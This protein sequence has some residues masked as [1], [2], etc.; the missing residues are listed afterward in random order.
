MHESEKKAGVPRTKAA[1][2][3]FPK[4]SKQAK[5]IGAAR[6]LLTTRPAAS[7]GSGPAG[8]A[9]PGRA[10]AAAG[11][12]SAP[13]AAQAPVVETEYMSD[14]EYVMVVCHAVRQ[15]LEP[16]S[17]AGKQ[18]GCLRAP[19]RLDCSRPRRLLRNLLKCRSWVCSGSRPDDARTRC[20]GV[21]QGVVASV[22][23]SQM[24]FQRK[25]STT[26]SNKAL[27]GPRC[28]LRGSMR[29]TDPH[30]LGA[31]C[32]QCRWR[33]VAHAVDHTS[34]PALAS[35]HQTVRKRRPGCGQRLC[36]WVAVTTWRAT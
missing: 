18:F 32:A 33:L 9:P 19:G 7:A 25:C 6:S 27:K 24:W 35:C 36:L 28:L 5:G 3:A 20:D 23:P 17:Q 34:R 12:T 15:C 21:H 14:N 11:T 4:R 8:P 22:T 16:L 2:P 31:C 29:V 30:N 13:C 26:C 1:R 10:R